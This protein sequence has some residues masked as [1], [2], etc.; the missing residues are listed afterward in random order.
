SKA[1]EIAVNVILPFA[2]SW[3]E[4]AN[5]AKLTENA[6]ELYRSYPKLSENYVTRHM[7]KQLGLDK[8]FDFTACR[9]QG[10]IHIFRNYCREGRC[11]QCP[12]G[13]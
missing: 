8:S 7:T 11:G 12:L 3:G 13:R 1:S 10:L 9:Q 4:L 5:E 6:I 2:F